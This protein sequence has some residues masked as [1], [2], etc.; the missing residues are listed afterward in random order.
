MNRTFWIAL[1]VVP[2]LLLSAFDAGAAEPPVT[3]FGEQVRVDVVTV[4]FYAVDTDGKP[5]SD[6]RRDEIELLVDGQRVEF[7]YFDRRDG[8]S[9]ATAA[10][11][12]APGAGEPGLAPLGAPR[13][14]FLLFD[15]AFSTPRGLERARAAAGRLLSSLSASDWLY[16]IRYHTQVGFEQQLGPIPADGPG[17]EA[18]LAKVAEL[19]PNIERVRFHAS[20]QPIANADC[21]NCQADDGLADAYLDTQQTEKANYAAEA[22][23]LAD[24]LETFATFLQQV[25]GP[26]LVLYFSQGPDSDLYTNGV[27]DRVRPL[28]TRFEKPLQALARSGASV[29]FV[30][31][32]VTT[33]PYASDSTQYGVDDDATEVN[34]IARG[35]TAL[36]MMAEV[37]GGKTVFDPNVEKLVRRIV[38]QT[39]AY[40]ELGYTASRLHAGPL[41]VEVRVHR[42][43]VEVWTPRNVVER[44]EYRE[45]SKAQRQFHIADLVWRGS[46][47]GAGR[48]F[49]GGPPLRLEGK[50]MARSEDAMRRLSFE[51]SWPQDLV[52]HTVDLYTVVLGGSPGAGAGRIEQFEA[53]SLT[54][55]PEKTP[56]LT[57]S[58]PADEPRVWGVVAV[59]P[60]SGTTYFRRVQVQPQ[61]AAAPPGPRQ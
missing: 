23:A 36:T 13:H 33:E 56:A 48:T 27:R 34:A 37:S 39:A 16:L 54:A 18:V 28:Y 21:N 52:L 31:A 32:E 7:E 42:P 20:L 30:S 9:R 47:P 51:V 49:A 11:P 55:N 57:V 40:Y 59:D 50:L 46:D 24:A 43:G 6:L 5:V 19:K 25:K 35:E 41:P 1:A 8:G 26:R 2:C 58:V 14:V 38:N 22:G 17:K 15:Q 29:F 61:T 3:G 10:A 60:S 45:L 4:P 53:V 44:I 12:V